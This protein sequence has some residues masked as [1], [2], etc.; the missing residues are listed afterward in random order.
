MYIKKVR[1]YCEEAYVNSTTYSTLFRGETI[2]TEPK[3]LRSLG[4]GKG[5]GIGAAGAAMIAPLFSSNMGHA[6]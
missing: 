3:D 2:N 6:L 4:Q 5:G 1:T